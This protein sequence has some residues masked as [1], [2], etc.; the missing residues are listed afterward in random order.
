MFSHSALQQIQRD[1]GQ[2]FVAYLSQLTETYRQRGEASIIALDD[3]DKEWDQIR[4]LGLELLA[5]GSREDIDL[6][7]GLVQ[8]LEPIWLVRIHPRDTLELLEKLLN[9]LSHQDQRLARLSILFLLGEVHRHLSDYQLMRDYFKLA[10]ELAEQLGRVWYTRQIAIKLAHQLTE[11]SYLD[12]ALAK[13]SWVIGDTTQLIDDQQAEAAII[14]G[15]IQVQQHNY[16]TA[17]H[18]YQRALDHF[19]R[20]ND[21]VTK[22]RT[23]TIMGNAYSTKGDYRSAEPYYIRALSVNQGVKS[24]YHQANILYNLALNANRWGAYE[25]AQYYANQ[26]LPDALTAGNARLIARVKNAVAIAHLRLGRYDLASNLF[27]ELTSYTR[28]YAYD[29]SWVHAIA[30]LVQTWNTAEV[31]ERAFHAL[32]KYLPEVL[33]VHSNNRSRFRVVSLGVW[34][35][36]GVNAM[37]SNYYR[38]FGFV[39][40]HTEMHWEAPT[41]LAKAKALRPDSA[42]NAQSTEPPLT[43]EDA[44]QLLAKVVENLVYE[45]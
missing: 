39:Q 35:L 37:S 36:A 33:D 11:E 41:I 18:Y 15:F 42:L 40:A 44:L 25:E 8:S 45:E 13:A 4:Q 9:H 30:N 29:N 24:K 27:Q 7:A 5:A 26:A 28:K 17:I 16:D 38:L 2:Y 12:E 3:L 22:I 34:T 32:R 6:C 20:Q 43:T 1:L 23:L 21:L 14:I 10:D 19:T 31:Y